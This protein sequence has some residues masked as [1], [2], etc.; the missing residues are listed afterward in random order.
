MS[1]MHRVLLWSWAATLSWGMPGCS[2][3]LAQNAT[4]TPV[5][6]LRGQPAAI[7][8][9]RNLFNGTCAVCHGVEASGGRGPALD[10]GRFPHG[11]EEY[12][13]F[14]NIKNGIGSGGMPSFAA[15][16]D[17]DVWALVSFLK[18]LAASP[19]PG[20]TVAP[21]LGDASEALRG[22]ALFFGSGGCARCHETADGGASLAADLSA[23]GR[24]GGDFIRSALSHEA[25]H[26]PP[27]VQ[28]TF[29]TGVTASGIVKAEDAFDI[30]M[31]TEQDKIMQ[32]ER[33]AVRSAHSI[34]GGFKPSE[35]PNPQEAGLILAY[36]SRQVGRGIQPSSAAR[37][38][39]ALSA[40]RIAAAADEPQ[41]WLTYWGD[42]AGHHFSALRQIDTS[43]VNLL[44]AQWAAALPG[45]SLLEAT[46]IVVDG[47]M[48][49]AGSPGDVYALDAM[50]G[51]QIWKF[52][53]KQDVVN[54]YQINPYNRGVAVMNGRVFVSTLDDLLIAIDAHTGRELWERRI[55]NTLDG[56]TM[57]GAPLVLKDRVVVGV[58]CGEYGVRG[59]LAAF[60]AATGESRW[61]LETIPGPH[62]A[63]HDSWPG[64]SWKRGGGGTWLTGSYDPSLNL[65]YWAVGNPAPY[66]NWKVRQ[67]DNLHTDSVLAIN[68]DSGTLI[69]AYQF[70]PNDSHDWDSAQD[71]VLADRVINGKPRK[72]LIHADR[73]GFLYMLDRTNG[74]FI[75]GHAFVRQTWNEGFDAK[76]RPRVSA[77]SLATP[78]GH[79]VFPTLSATNFQAPSFDARVG[80]LFLAFRDTEGY[81]AYGEPDFEPGKLYTAPSRL[82]RPQSTSSSVSGIRALAV[83]SGKVVWSYSLPRF[84]PQAGVLATDGNLVFAGSADGSF[85]A[86][87]ADSGAPLWHFRTAARI[88][89]SPV[90]YAVD[91][92]QF[93]AIA[94]GNL[95][96]SFALPQGR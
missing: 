79:V 54:P 70:T 74:E 5:N 86:L 71:L 82:P 24:K 60:D 38:D 26:E 59:F 6:P 88:F 77:A 19:A 50:T 62:E 43:N 14:R 39:V 37:R 64:D 75:S 49:V 7:D 52:T 13:V 2:P 83:D 15:L 1:W 27:W 23:V 58:G 12:E 56:Y 47:V 33:S 57:T 22:E 20:A 91:G 94:A 95:V 3:L 40:Q 89:A 53:R 72:V 11:G 44:Q 93:I 96:Y 10:T 29:D 30:L 73:N 16:A 31:L 76:G 48:Y 51:L 67:G 85:F 9:G 90:S 92:R 32:I 84:A 28:L 25:M 18:S 21:P 63:G 4:D 35:T 45:P 87:N 65:L 69:W 42:Y 61:R 8:S 34:E 55:A 78:Q 66:N 80:T 41:N 36:L 68:P 46:P 81:G 17:G